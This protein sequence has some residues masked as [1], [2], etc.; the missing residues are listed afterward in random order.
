MAAPVK[1]NS[2]S[3]GLGI[4][5]LCK[6][7]ST[8]A[9]GITNAKPDIQALDIDL[10][11]LKSK[12][13]MLK[14]RLENQALS[15][16]KTNLNSALESPLMNCDQITTFIG[17]FK[18]I[19]G[20]GGL[21]VTWRKIKYSYGGLGT[22]TLRNELAVHRLSLNI[23]ISLVNFLDINIESA[24]TRNSDAKIFIYLT[25]MMDKLPAILHSLEKMKCAALSLIE[26]Q[27]PAKRLLLVET[28]SI[29]IG[30]YLD[31][32]TAA[33]RGAYYSNIVF[34]PTD[35]RNNP[36]D[37]I[38]IFVKGPGSQTHV[39][40]VKSDQTINDLKRMIEIRTG[41]PQDLLYFVSA[42][43]VL[44]SD[45]TPD[46]LNIVQDSTLICNARAKGIASKI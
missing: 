3:T 14:L 23:V 5:A 17:S 27:P 36:E 8:K 33:I 13:E 15:A 10:E 37:A 40:H 25:G 19:G 12:R 43:K 31:K 6:Q 28:Q 1:S 41:V 30:K 42:G 35:T 21:V 20:V 18:A 32:E 38:Q 39:M 9:R 29:E 26:S 22:D 45:G 4:K 11:G 16:G 24:T 2:A 34:V 46:S 7:M 44:P